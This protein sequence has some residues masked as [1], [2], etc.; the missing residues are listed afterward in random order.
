MLCPNI[1][2]ARKAPY[3]SLHH[4]YPYGTMCEPTAFGRPASGNQPDG[5]TRL[6]LTIPPKRNV[7]RDTSNYETPFFSMGAGDRV[8]I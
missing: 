5:I 4:M 8:S 1:P 7:S 3:G 2:Y 6:R